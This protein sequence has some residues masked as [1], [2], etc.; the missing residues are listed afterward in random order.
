MEISS[1]QFSKE[2]REK[3][4]GSIAPLAGH[5]VTTDFLENSP[6]VERMEAE[7]FPSE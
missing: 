2:V 7:S 1:S 3:W 5:E 4:D 6:T